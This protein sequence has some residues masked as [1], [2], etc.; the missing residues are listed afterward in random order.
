MHKLD[1]ARKY[2]KKQQKRLNL[3]SGLEYIYQLSQ[4]QNTK[5]RIEMKRF[6]EETIYYA[7]YRS[8]SYL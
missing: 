3:F 1:S 5:L 8:V 6:T 4:L 2:I 7:E